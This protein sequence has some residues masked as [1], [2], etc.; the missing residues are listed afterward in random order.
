MSFSTN[1]LFLTTGSPLLSW[2][3]HEFNYTDTS[4]IYFYF[5]SFSK[6][7]NEGNGEGL[8][9]NEGQTIRSVLCCY[10]G[11]VL[12]PVT[13]SPLS[14]AAISICVLVIKFFGVCICGPL[15]V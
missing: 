14:F 10:V 9:E 7:G 8:R 13:D 2:S 4:L 3:G 5:L 1:R 12:I 11:G 6:T 15:K